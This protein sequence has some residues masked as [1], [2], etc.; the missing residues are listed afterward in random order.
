MTRG[1]AL[2]AAYTFSKAIDN[3]TNELFSSTVNPRRA[4]D[5]FDLSQE[6][7][8]SA[9]DVPHRFAASFNYDI[10]FFNHSTNGLL[11]GV[12]G[13]WQIN[14]VFQTQSGQLMTPQSLLD[15][16][17]NGDAAGDRTIVN[18]S[19]VPGTGSGVYGVNALGQRIVDAS[20]AD[21]LGD[22][23][24][25]AYVA[26][27]PSAQYIQAGFGAR[28]NAGRNTLRTNNW[29]RTD[30]TFVKNIRFGG[31]RY[32][33][34]LAAEVGNFF[35]Q[36]IRTIGDFGSP[37]FVNQN[38]FNG[39]NQFGIGAVSFAFPDVTSPLFNSYSAGNFSGRTVQLRAKFIF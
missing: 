22:P 31:E 35:N 17:R 9:I 34:Q 8:L 20:G 7:S 21:V 37:F 32:N 4:Q 16:N 6:R 3:S 1:L 39:T 23:S 19:G 5:G 25:V 18:L 33:I 27:N 11:K 36:R 38:D 10:P 29:N 2:T 24:T 12:L 26:I 13:G 30:M 14:G 28:A 15:S